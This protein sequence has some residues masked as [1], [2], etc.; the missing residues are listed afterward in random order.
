MITGAFSQFENPC[1]FIRASPSKLEETA[2][3]VQEMGCEVHIGYHSVLVRKAKWR[4][5]RPEFR[6]LLPGYILA[7]IPDQKVREVKEHKHVFSEMVSL[8]QSVMDRE[9][10]PFFD[11]IERGDFNH[12]G[13]F[14]DL[15]PGEI[16]NLTGGLFEDMQFSFSRVADSG[17]AL[18]GEVITPYGSIKARIPVDQVE[19]KAS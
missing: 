1:F 7:G 14:G 3:D 12:D 13:P 10:I 11:R 16:M 19:R 18:D 4:R 17:E 9:V 5:W 15:K 8:S 2:R 6:P